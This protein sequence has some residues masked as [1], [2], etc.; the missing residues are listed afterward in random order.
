VILTV[1]NTYKHYLHLIGARPFLYTAPVLSTSMLAT[2]NF[3]SRGTHCEKSEV[4]R[5][6]LQPGSRNPTTRVWVGRALQDVPDRIIK[7]TCRW[8]PNAYLGYIRSNVFNLP[9]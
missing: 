9:N 8:S 4:R 1:H 3:L 5:R 6:T 7:K 2:S